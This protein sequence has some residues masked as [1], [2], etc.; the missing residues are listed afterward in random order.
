MTML[1]TL[2]IQKNVTIERL[3]VRYQEK[4]RSIN[5]QEKHFVMLGKFSEFLVILDKHFSISSSPY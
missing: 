5:N 1:A 3:S 4:N 2:F